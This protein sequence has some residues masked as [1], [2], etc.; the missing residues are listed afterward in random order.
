MRIKLQ[1]K[2]IEDMDYSKFEEL[3]SILKRGG[4]DIETYK[5]SLDEGI[6]YFIVKWKLKKNF[7]YADMKKETMN[8]MKKVVL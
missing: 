3:I 5:T 4:W 6:K 2:E 7:V 1:I 8:C